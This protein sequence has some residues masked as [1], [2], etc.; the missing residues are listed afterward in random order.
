M[1]RSWRSAA[2]LA[3]TREAWYVG[4]AMVARIPTIETTI[5]NSINVKPFGIRTTRL[6][7]AIFGSIERDVIAFRHYI[8]DVFAAPV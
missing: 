7:V 5:N 6:P 1:K 4:I 8:V 2:S 3:L